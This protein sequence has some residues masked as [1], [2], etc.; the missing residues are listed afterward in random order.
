[1]NRKL[2]ISDL[3]GTLLDENKQVTPATRKILED[4]TKA[5]HIFAIGTGRALSNALAMRLSLGLADVCRY[6]VAYN[7]AQIYDALE[8]KMI[9]EQTIAPQTVEKILDLAESLDVHC[10][11]YL[12]PYIV[13]RRE[14]EALKAY[15]FHIHMPVIVTDDVS[16]KL[17]V[18]PC[19]L[20]GI[21]LYERAK[22]EAFQAALQQDFSEEVQGLFS[23]PQYLDIL[24]AKVNKGRALSVLRE[25]L[26]IG[27]E[28]TLAAGDEENDI[29]MILEAGIGIGMKNG[30]DRVKAAADVVTEEDNAHDGL[31]ELLKRYL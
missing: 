11:T 23:S 14:S 10:H 12:G 20:L 22:L 6:V 4:W 2:F 31:A 7:G 8:E 21:E 3:D 18:D 17:S 27:K 25:A 13:T 29:S 28:N 9:F 15:R 5:G 1:M 16:S 26:D 24:P 19:L 30:A